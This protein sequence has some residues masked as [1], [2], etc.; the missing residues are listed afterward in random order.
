MEGG[1]GVWLCLWFCR[2]WRAGDWF[3]LGI[4]EVVGLKT[5][6]ETADYFGCVGGCVLPEDGSR[7]EAR[8]QGF[9]DLGVKGVWVGDG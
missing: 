9:E 8:D 2:G 5:A 4:Q 7:E 6:D 1:V 3:A